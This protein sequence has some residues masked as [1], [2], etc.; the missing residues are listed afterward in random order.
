ML[1]TQ[2]KKKTIKTHFKRS[3]S[4]LL[5]PFITVCKKQ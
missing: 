5:A 1:Q 2:K 3:F 4:E